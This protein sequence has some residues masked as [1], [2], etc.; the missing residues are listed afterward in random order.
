[1]PTLGWVIFGVGI[2]VFGIPLMVFVLWYISKL[3]SKDDPFNR[4][5]GRR[6]ATACHQ[7]RRSDLED[8]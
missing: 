8:G 7:C 2:S 6:R 1:M 4:A 3:C 5:G